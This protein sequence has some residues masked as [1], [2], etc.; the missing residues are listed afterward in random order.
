MWAPGG[1]WHCRQSD[2]T[3]LECEVPAFMGIINFSQ[4]RCHFVGED[5]TRELGPREFP[6][7]WS[8]IVLTTKPFVYTSLFLSGFSL[9]P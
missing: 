4:S 9:N 3:L 8:P 7:L 5:D 6:L 1:Q 2:G